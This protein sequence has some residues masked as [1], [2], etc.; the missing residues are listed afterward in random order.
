MSYISVYWSTYSTCT[1]GAGTGD[2]LTVS[3]NFS[4]THSYPR[5]RLLPSLLSLLARPPGVPG[6]E[7]DMGG[8]ARP[9]KASAATLAGDAMADTPA[10]GAA[11][12]AT[13]VRPD[14]PM[15]AAMLA[16]RDGPEYGDDGRTGDSSE[17]TSSLMSLREETRGW[18]REHALWMCR[19]HDEAMLAITLGV[20]EVK[21]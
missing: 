2:S 15:D 21:C 4:H 11:L 8:V 1:T 10:D 16:P 5:A 6:A 12:I 3:F 19:I 20:W 13:E 18:E 9:G 17:S 7:V 14:P